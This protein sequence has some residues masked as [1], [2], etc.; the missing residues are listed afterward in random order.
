MAEGGYDDRETLLKYTDDKDYTEDK[1]GTF[2][3]NPGG[4]ST[5]GDNI[6]MRTLRRDQLD[7]PSPP[8]T[9]YDET[10]FGGTISSEDIE[11][12]LN[13][14]RKSRTGLLNTSKIELQNILL[15]EADKQKEIQRVK[16]IFRLRYRPPDK[17]DTL[18][19]RFSEKKSQSGRGGGQARRRDQNYFR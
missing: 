12:R 10:N 19:I 1:E 15:S 13:S 8:D 14:L 9:S 6:E 2:V 7:L 18:N 3:I 11:R 17:L 16:K 4:T 5:P